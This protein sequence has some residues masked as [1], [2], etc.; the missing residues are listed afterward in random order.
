VQEVYSAELF[1]T[2]GKPDIEKIQPFT[3]SMPDN[4]YWSVGEKLGKAWSAGKVFKV[5]LDIR[6]EMSEGVTPSQPPPILL[7]ISSL[8]VLLYFFSKDINRP[9]TWATPGR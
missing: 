8:F 6:I 9:S 1:L 7:L 3:L 2:E 5:K 4:Y